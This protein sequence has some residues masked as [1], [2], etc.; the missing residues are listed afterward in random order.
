MACRPAA[1]S[2]AGNKPA[3]FGLETAQ[4]LP[5][6]QEWSRRKDVGFYTPPSPIHL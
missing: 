1:G 4:G 5:L 2:T 6:V 3:S